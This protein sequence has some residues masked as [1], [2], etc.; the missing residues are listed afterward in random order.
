MNHKG[1]AFTGIAFF[2]GKPQWQE[3]Q[4]APDLAA[5]MRWLLFDLKR[6]SG[7]R[8][9]KPQDCFFA[10]NTIKTKPRMNIKQL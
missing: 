3:V 1:D 7:N 8:D 5:I 2:L 4:K 6:V 9:P 10:P